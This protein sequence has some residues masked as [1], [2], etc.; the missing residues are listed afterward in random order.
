MDSSPRRKEPLCGGAPSSLMVAT[1]ATDGGCGPGN[2]D[3]PL[4]GQGPHCVR[5]STR[6]ATRAMEVEER[7]PGDALQEQKPPPRAAAERRHLAALRWGWLPASPRRHW[8]AVR[9][10]PWTLQPSSSFSPSCWRRMSTRSRRRERR[11]RRRSTGLGNSAARRSRSSSWPCASSVTSGLRL[12][13]T[14]RRKKRRTRCSRSSRSRAP[15]SRARCGV[16]NTLLN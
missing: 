5:R 14:R 11:R 10:R 15:S 9:A 6:P 3:A 8:R 1:S 4:V 12:R 7:E 13:R 16:C 2:S